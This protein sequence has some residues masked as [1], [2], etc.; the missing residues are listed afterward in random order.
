[1]GYGISCGSPEEDR[2]TTPGARFTELWAQAERDL[3]GDTGDATFTVRYG[4]L[5]DGGRGYGW[6]A[7]NEGEGG[8]KLPFIELWRTDALP[9]P[10]WTPDLKTRPLL[11]ACDLAH[12]HGHF[13][14]DKNRE[15]TPEY[16]AALEVLRL[17]HEQRERMPTPEERAL[18]Y[19]EEE[20]AWAYAR[21]TLVGLGVDEWEAF[22]ARKAEALA[23]YRAPL[24]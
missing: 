20:R 23:S 9:D 22:D 6:Y 1:M 17:Y 19:A 5:L 4:R 13:L 12:E 10:Q 8:R 14:S 24:A 2:M 16:E 18:I 3:A 11:D 21:K 15:R 7:P